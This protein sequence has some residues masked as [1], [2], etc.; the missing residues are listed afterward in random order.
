MSK[1]YQMPLFAA[2][3]ASVLAGSIRAETLWIAR[4]NGAFLS[5]FDS[6]SPGTLLS[7]VSVSGLVAGDSIYGIDFHP[8]TGVLYGYAGASGRLYTLDKVTGVATAVGTS[9]TVA[10]FRTAMSFNTAGTEIRIVHQAG[11]NFRINPL[12]G[13]LLGTDTST[14]ED[15]LN[16]IAY[17]STPTVYALEDGTGFSFSIGSIGGSP[18]SPNSGLVS[19]IGTSGIFTTSQYNFDISESTGVA[20]VDDGGGGGGGTLNLWTLNLVTGVGTYVGA[21]DTGL[22]NSRGLAV[23][24]VPEPASLGL[25]VLCSLSATG[26][27]RRKLSKQVTRTSFKTRNTNRTLARSG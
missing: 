26:F 8:V 7:S 20:Y 10:N 18:N 19:L 16:G 3:I 6:S 2:L 1:C 11:T 22:S 9:L 24:P 27:V 21:I 25:M 23:Q 5:S 15:G 14:N 4:A 12:D 13:T 17:T